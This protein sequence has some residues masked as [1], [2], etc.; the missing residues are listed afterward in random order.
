V[1]SQQPSIK[2]KIL[3][4][5]L[6]W[7]IGTVV[8]IIIVIVTLLSTLGSTGKDTQLEIARMTNYLHDKYGQDFIVSNVRV[9]G[10]GIGAEGEIDADAYPKSD[11]SLKFQIGKPEHY[12]LA[13]IYPRDT[14]LEVLWSKQGNTLVEEFLK[15]ELPGTDGYILTIQPGNEVRN[16]INGHT[17]SFSEIQQTHPNG[18]SYSLS[19]RST[20]TNLIH[21]PSQD[22][23]ARAFKV[24]T[25]VKQ[26]G[27]TAVE[28]Y[29]L[30]KDSS[31]NKIDQGNQV[32]YQ[33]S[34]A[35]DRYKIQNVHSPADLTGY[36]KVIGN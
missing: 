1:P 19:V 15:R 17:P 30:Y 6:L 7:L 13:S 5:F 31:Y 8:A 25:F 16:S 2:I 34:I 26:A 29:Y 22:Q 33:Y 9:E 36:F 20:A 4:S 12:Q 35:V 3:K 21:Q 27:S 32:R 18:F 28:A 14:F 23:L 24:V 11:P 10:A